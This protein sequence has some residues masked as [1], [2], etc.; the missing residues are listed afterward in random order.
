MKKIAFLLLVSFLA[1]GLSA[2]VNEPYVFADFTEKELG[3]MLELCNK[4]GFGILIQKTPFSTYGHYNWN[5]AF[6][7][8]GTASVMQMVATASEAGIRLG[9]WTQDNAI[10]A[11]DAFFS[12]EN[13]KYFHREARVE[14]YSEHDADETTIAL[15]RSEVFNKPSSLNLLMIEDEMVTYSTMEFSGDIAVLHQCTRGAYGTKAV[16][17]PANAEAYKIL[18]MPEYFVVPV[19]ELRD[20]V[21]ECYDEK[22][23]LFPV[24]LPKGD[25][26]QEWIDESIRVSQVDRWESAGTSLSSLGW[27]LIH[28]SDKKHASTSMEEL[29]WMLSK[30]AGFRACYGLVVDPEAMTGHGMLDE[31]LATTNRWNRLLRADVFTESQRQ[32][33]RDPYLDWHLEQQDS[34]HYLLYPLD[35]SRRFYCNFEV[36]DPALLRSE[37]WNWKSDEVGRFGLRIKVDG[38]VDVINPMVNTTRGLVMFP[39]TIKPGQSLL[40]DFGETAR[41]VDAD[42]RIIA[43]VAIEGLPELDEGSNEVYFLCE[44]DPKAEQHPV[45]TLRYITREQPETVTLEGTPHK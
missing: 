21:Q 35:F 16:D 37:T 12:S 27:F 28:L 5:D 33:L 11:D 44:V 2:Q 34:M 17:H 45:V 24:S 18:D 1:S 43:E 20:R 9:V 4:G 41:V 6:A 25:S 22:L 32:M 30:A 26:G 36:A 31:L 7:L 40:Y 3:T 42:C 23:Q 19:G 8:Q 38:E 39:C 29:E 15:R 14:F 13:F 10:T